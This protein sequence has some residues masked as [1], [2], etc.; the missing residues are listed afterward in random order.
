[1]KLVDTWGEAVASQ[2]PCLRVLD[3]VARVQVHAE[4]QHLHLCPEAALFLPEMSNVLHKSATCFYVNC[5]CSFNY[6]FQIQVVNDG[7]IDA[8][9]LSNSMQ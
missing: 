5:H 8:R 3:L 6:V 1:M 9:L 2:C 4:R 7:R